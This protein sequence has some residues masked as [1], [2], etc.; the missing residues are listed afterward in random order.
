MSDGAQGPNAAYVPRRLRIGVLALQGDFREHAE[1]LRRVGAEPVEVR[2]ADQLE[3]ID[4]LIIPGGEST[5]IGKL[6][7]T[8]NLLEPLRRLIE[9]GRPVWGTCAGMI[10]LAE[11]IGGL[12]QPLLGGLHVRVKRNAFGR[13][14]DS[15]ET[16]IP[17]PAV[18]ADPIHA[19]FIRAPWVEAAGPDVEVL[20]RLEDG[21]V[22]A[23]RQGHL[24]G[25]SFH[26]ELTGDPRFHEYFLHMCDAPESSA[27]ASAGSGSETTA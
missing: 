19:V 24:L 3:G 4:G 16:D 22:V 26:P 17:M 8:Y 2:R 1:M 15:F 10:L 5:T 9:G 20:G 21:T 11:D 27:L 14:L 25:T 18:G 12:D 6:M 13:Q 23:V 7:V